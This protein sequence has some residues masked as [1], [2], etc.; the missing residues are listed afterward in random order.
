MSFGGS[1]CHHATRKKSLVFLLKFLSDLVPFEPSHY[2][3]VNISGTV[4]LWSTQ[5]YTSVS[6]VTVKPTSWVESIV[7]PLVLRSWWGRCVNRKY[8]RTWIKLWLNQSCCWSDSTGACPPPPLH[9]SQTPQ[10]PDGVRVP[11]QD[12]TERPQGERRRLPV[13]LLVSTVP[14]H[15]VWFMFHELWWNL[16]DMLFTWTPWVR[17]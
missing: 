4:L 16:C 11:G 14:V 2:L 8:S 17:S 13:G 12:Q 5:I 6:Q 10:P 3:K 1:S 9:P 7:T 15:F